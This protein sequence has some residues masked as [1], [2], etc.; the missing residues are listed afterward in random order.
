MMPRP[1]F[2]WSMFAPGSAESV[3]AQPLMAVSGVRS[4]CETDEINS[5]WIFSAW[6]ILSDMS[7]MLSTSSPSSSR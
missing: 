4:S 5:C 2:V 1:R 6:L 3:S 7:L